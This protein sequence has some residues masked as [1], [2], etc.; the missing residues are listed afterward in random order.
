M[1]RSSLRER[2]SGHPS[3]AAAETALAGGEVRSK[4]CGVEGVSRGWP[5]GAACPGFR[6]MSRGRG[7]RRRLSSISV[8]NLEKKRFRWPQAVWEWAAP[9]RAFGPWRH[10]HSAH[11]KCAIRHLNC[12]KA[13]QF[14]TLSAAWPSPY[15]NLL[16]I[17]EMQPYCN[18]TVFTISRAQVRT[19]PRRKEI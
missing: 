10:D 17:G 12:P 4:E 1:H 11:K 9:S 7:R 2:T 8:H 6:S 14:T 18:A 15:S 13:D 3:G 19:R 5:G 16:D